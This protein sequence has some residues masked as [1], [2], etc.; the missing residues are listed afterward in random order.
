MLKTSLGRVGALVAR[1]A[2]F[3]TRFH[4]DTR[5][6]VVAVVALSLVP[7][8]GALA[9][10]SE[11]ASWNVTNRGMQNAADS[12]AVAAATAGYTGNT[13]YAAEG[14]TVAARYGFTGTDHTSSC[15]TLSADCVSVLNGQTCPDATTGCYKVTINQPQA[16][17]LTQVLSLVGFNGDTTVGATTARAVAISASAMAEIQQTIAPACLI[18][19][20]GGVT[21]NGGSHGNIGG[22]N[23]ASAT[24]ATCNG[25]NA[26]INA[27]Q[28]IYVTN[29]KNAGCQPASKQASVV[30][31]YASSPGTSTTVPSGCTSI[32]SLTT[33]SI[34]AGGC[35]KITG[36]LALTGTVTTSA[37]MPTQIFVVNGNLTGAGTLLTPGGTGLAGKTGGVSLIF[38]GASGGD[39]FSGFTGTLNMAAP[40]AGTYSGVSIVDKFT[41]SGKKAAVYA[42][43]LPTWDLTGLVYLPNTDFTLS[44]AV[45]KATSGYNCFVLVTASLQF[46]GTADLVSN[47]TS[48]CSSAGLIPPSYLL[49]FRAP[50]VS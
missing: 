12:A 50:L 24:D 37:S 13:A 45:S 9:L 7:L 5:A 10:G 17:L 20:T 43:N 6:N 40:T 34:A 4:N 48:E 44:G 14:Y 35:F 33:A 32:A 31:P 19:L 8:I 25:S 36:D 39:I 29:N 22:C 46:N 16:L 38:S 27:G 1:A 3:A 15:T 11:A 21:I 18:A 26:S 28:I 23:I 47:P 42:G 30:D 49:G 41:F 2:D